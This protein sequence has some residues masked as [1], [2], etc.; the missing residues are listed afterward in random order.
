[1]WLVVTRRWGGFERQVYIPS[2]PHVHKRT[3]CFVSFF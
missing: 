3:H 1:M 2:S